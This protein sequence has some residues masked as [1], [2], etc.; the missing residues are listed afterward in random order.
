MKLRDF[1]R[2]LGA[3]LGA[4][5]GIV[6]V[7]VMTLV[8]VNL[9][10]TAAREAIAQSRSGLIVSRFVHTVG[11]M[12]PPRLQEL[13]ANYVQQLDE[14]IGQPSGGDPYRP[15][16]VDGS[17]PNYGYPTNPSGQYP[18]PTYDG[19]PQNSQYVPPTYAPA[20][21]RR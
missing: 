9:M 20:N 18:R 11:P 3:V 15:Y 2:Q 6:I 16:Q 21:G 8:C 14:V 7:T 5:K 13:L 12:T 19:Y 1:D 10:T 4:A 17:N